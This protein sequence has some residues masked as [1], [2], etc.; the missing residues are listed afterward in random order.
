VVEIEGQ[1]R[2]DV[3]IDDLGV[4]QEQRGRRGRRR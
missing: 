2:V 4:R 1:G 3:P